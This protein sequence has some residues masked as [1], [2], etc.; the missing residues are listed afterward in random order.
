VASGEVRDEAVMIRLALAPDGRLLPDPAARAPGRGVWVTAN[1]KAVA[2]ATRRGQLVR[3][4]DGKATVPADIE[5]LIADALAA[6]ALQMLGFAR[7]AGELAVG[8]TDVMDSLSRRRPGLMIE[9]F[10]GADGGRAKVMNALVSR[11]NTPT[12]ALPAVRVIGCYSSEELALALGRDRVIHAALREG[13]LANKLLVDFDRLAGFRSLAPPEW[14][15]SGD[16]SVGDGDA[17][18]E[19]PP[20]E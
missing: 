2:D 10:D 14:G 11:W 8:F 4:F 16:A 5:H 7:R 15:L 1:A 6:R 18:M 19:Q 17:A 20:E 13:A 3:G 9:A 12:S